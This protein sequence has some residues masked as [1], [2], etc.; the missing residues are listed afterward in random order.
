[1]SYTGVLSEKLH[2]ESMLTSNN[3]A[4]NSCRFIAR[5]VLSYRIEELILL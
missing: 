5:K 2:P 1:M 4:T 3:E